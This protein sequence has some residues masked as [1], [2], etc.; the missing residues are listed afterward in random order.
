MA[1]TENE[2]QVDVG[3]GRFTFYFNVD[4]YHLTMNPS[5]AN[6]ISDLVQRKFG[7]KQE[8]LAF[9]LPI[10]G[11]KQI[12]FD[13]VPYLGRGAGKV[14]NLTFPNSNLKQK[15]IIALFEQRA[16]K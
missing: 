8:K 4:L 10:D 3:G 2:V 14:T 13:F 7:W 16:S 1:R 5:C 6:N 9:C 15:D 11:N 12:D